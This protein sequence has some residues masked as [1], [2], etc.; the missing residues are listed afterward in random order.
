MKVN[1]GENEA[2]FC[3]EL[4]QLAEGEYNGR[5]VLYDVNE[6]GSEIVHDVV[7]AAF[8]IRK[9]FR[10]SVNDTAKRWG[11]QYWGS[12]VFPTIEILGE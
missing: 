9:E 5:I 2:S 6:Y 3:L 1:E 10:S 7:N 8:A 12:I 11:Q 4:P